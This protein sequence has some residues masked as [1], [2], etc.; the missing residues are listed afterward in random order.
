ME[1]NR[2]KGAKRA[3]EPEPEGPEPTKKGTPR[4]MF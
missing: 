4:K 3:I 2:L 1:L